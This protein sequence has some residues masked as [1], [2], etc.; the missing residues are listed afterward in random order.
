MSTMH[1]HFI[2]PL[3]VLFLR[4]NKLFGAPGS[5][6]EGLIPPW[7]SVAAG[8]IR[9]QLLARDGV[10]LKA[11]AEG[12]VDHPD[13]GRPGSP[14]RFE[15]C[16]F[17]VARIDPQGRLSPLQALPADLVVEAEHPGD[18]SSWQVRRMLPAAPAQGLA[19]SAALPLL[20][21]LPQP[22][23]LKARSGLWLTAQGWQRYLQ[24]GLPQPDELVKASELW[25]IDE[26]VG[27]G[28]DAERRAAADSQLYT[29]QAIALRPGVGFLV[30]SRGATLPEASSLRF[31]GDGRGA[32]LRQPP[33]GTLWPEP[34]WDALARAGRCR[35]V[36]TTPGLFAGGWR[37]P[38]MQADGRVVLPGLT[39]RCVSAAV[40]RAEVI[41][42]WDLANKGPRAA[43]RAAPTG[44]VYWLDEL[45]TTADALRK[46]ADDGLWSG[47]DEDAAIADAAERRTQ[48]FNRCMAAPF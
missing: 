3:D 9:S 48:G 15:L 7:P 22:R 8:A 11:Y 28:M 37:L 31:G 30:R 39:A 6:G 14:G 17:G 19:S 20:P 23:R 45:E 1:T 16:G 27:I 36:L 12:K 26:R 42:G 32:A 34:D 18:R 47:T 13:L 5:H 40:P 33:G 21:V 38:G 41:S 46:L 10:D 29:V 24:G 35:L 4:G 44:S 43:Q 2:E 25:Q